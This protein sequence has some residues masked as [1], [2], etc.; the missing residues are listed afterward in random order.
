MTL[1]QE[2]QFH[3]NFVHDRLEEEAIGGPFSL[4]NFLNVG[5]TMNLNARAPRPP[6]S[7]FWI[8]NS[9]YEE[10]TERL[11]PPQQTRIDT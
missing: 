11:N 7:E 9:A 5:C 3:L 1:E 2:K 8:P 4:I 6:Q 10:V